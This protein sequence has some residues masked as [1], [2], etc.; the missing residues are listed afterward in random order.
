MLD[1]F[2]DNPANTD[3][4]LQRHCLGSPYLLSVVTFLELGLKCL[5]F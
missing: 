3:I 1:H 4:F 5:S 2:N